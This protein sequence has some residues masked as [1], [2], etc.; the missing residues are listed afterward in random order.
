MK[1]F[2]SIL[3]SFL[4]LFALIPVN[5]IADESISEGDAGGAPSE[6]GVLSAAGTNPESPIAENGD[7]AP[8]GSSEVDEPASDASAPIEE[9]DSS[10]DSVLNGDVDPENTGVSDNASD[11]ALQTEPNEEEPAEDVSSDENPDENETDNS[12]LTE[13]ERMEE[14]AAI[15]EIAVGQTVTGTLDEMESTHTVRLI[16]ERNSA[17]TLTL[18]GGAI[19]TVF[20]EQSEKLLTQIGEKDEA[21]EWKPAETGLDATQGSYLV[22]FSL[23]DSEPSASFSWTANIAE[24]NEIDT[25]EIQQTRGHVT[26]SFDGYTVTADDSSVSVELSASAQSD[27]PAIRGAIGGV[28]YD[29]LLDIVINGSASEEIQAG[30]QSDSLKQQS[31]QKYRVIRILRDNEAERVSEATITEEGSLAFSVRGD[32]LYVLISLKGAEL[33]PTKPGTSAFSVE[34]VSG[35]SLRGEQYVWTP[36]DSSDSNRFV[37]RVHYNL[38]VYSDLDEESVRMIIPKQILKDRDNQYADEIELTIPSQADLESGDSFDADAYFAWREET[39]GAGQPTGNIILYNFRT[40]NPGTNSGSAEL[41]YIPTKSAFAYR[42]YN[43]KDPAGTCSDDFHAVLQLLDGEPIDSEHIAVGIDTEA[44][45]TAISKRGFTLSSGW[46]SS[47]GNASDFGVSASDSSCKYLIW[48]INSSIRATQPYT[49]TINDFPVT[50][51]MEVIGYQWG[52]DSGFSVPAEDGSYSKTNQQGGSRYDFVLTRV[53]ESVYRDAASGQD[54]ARWSVE[55]SAMVTLTPIDGADVVS[56]ATGTGTFSQETPVFYDQQAQFDAWK[57]GDGSARMNSLFGGTSGSQVF[58]ALSFTAGYYSRTDLER[59]G[60]H[61]ETNGDLET[62]DSLDYAVWAWSM[63]YILTKDWNYKDIAS[64]NYGYFRNYVILDQWDSEVKL[65]HTAEDLIEIGKGDY[66]IKK[67][68]FNTLFYDAQ[69]NENTQKFAQGEAVGDRQ[70][71]ADDALGGIGDVLHI[72]GKTGSGEWVELLKKEYRANGA[73]WVNEEYAQLNDNTLTFL[74]SEDHSKD[75]LLFRTVI[76]TRHYVASVGAVPEIELFASEKVLEVVNENGAICLY[77]STSADLYSLWEGETQHVGYNAEGQV[78]EI[79]YSGEDYRS[80]PWNL[81]LGDGDTR[82]Y[83]RFTHIS[84]A[85]RLDYDYARTSPLEETAT[86]QNYISSLRKRVTSTGNDRNQSR[87][88]IGWQVDMEEWLR[89]NGIRTVVPQISGVFYDLLPEGATLDM[90]TLKVQNSD[91]RTN[92]PEDWNRDF[93]SELIPNWRGSGRTMLIVH[94][95][96]WGENYSLSYETVHPWTSIKEYGNNVYNPVAYETGNYSITSGKPD[97]ASGFTYANADERAWMTGLDPNGEGEQRFLYADAKTSISALITLSN[98]TFKRV[99][100]MKDTLYNNMAYV[101]QNEIYV[102]RLSFAPDMQSPSENLLFIDNL[103]NSNA[104]GRQWQGTLYS[105]DPNHPEYAIDVTQLRTAGANPT[106]YLA[107]H[108]VEITNYGNDQSVGDYLSEKGFVA[109]EAF[110]SSHS[111]SEVKSVA[112]YCGDDFR[113]NGT[114][115]DND[116]SLAVYLYMKSPDYIADRGN[117]YPA[118]YNSFALALRVGVSKDDGTTEYIPQL[119]VTPDVVTYCRVSGNVPLKKISAEDSVTA[120]S[121]VQFKLSGTSYYTGNYFE[122]FETTGSDGRLIF[123][124]V[125]RGSYVLEEISCPQEWVLSK[126]LLQIVIDGYG[127]LWAADINV[128][129]T[130]DGQ[131]QTDPESGKPLLLDG[132]IASDDYLYSSEKTGEHVITVQD[133]LRVYSDIRFTKTNKRAGQPIKDVEFRLEGVSHYET[134]V[135]LTATSDA[136]GVVTF[137]DVEWGT[138]SLTETKTPSNYFPLPSSV[139]IMVEV[140]GDHNVKIYEVD[141]VTNQPKE[142]S[143]WLS[144][145]RFGGVSVMNPEKNTDV[146]FFKAE[147]TNDTCRYLPG[148][149]FTLVGSSVDGNSVNREAT[150]DENGHVL[151]ERVEEGLYE[152]TE[153]VAPQNIR[154]TE[155]GEAEFGGEIN[156]KADSNTYYLIVHDNGTFTICLKNSDGSEGAEVERDNSGEYVF[157]NTPIADGELLITK[158]WIDGLTGTAALNRPYPQLSLMTEE[159]FAANYYTVTF[160]AHGGYFAN[161][162]KTYAIRYRADQLPTA[163]QAAAVPAPVRT[164]YLFDGWIYKLTGVEDILTFDLKNYTEKATITVYANWTPARLWEYEY[165]GFAQE[166]TAP[167][168]GDYKMEAWGANGGDPTKYML[169]RR[170]GGTGAYTSGIIHLEEGQKIYVYVG[171]KGANGYLPS[172]YVQIAGGWNGGGYGVDDSNNDE[173]SGGGG[174]ATDFRLVDGAWNSF[175]SLKSRIMVA[176]GGGGSVAVRK[177]APSLLNIT[178]PMDGH[179]ASLPL[180]EVPGFQYTYKVA[181]S[182][183]GEYTY[184]A[185]TA[186][187][188]KWYYPGSFGVGGHADNT[189]YRCNHS[190]GGAGGGWYGGVAGSTQYGANSTSERNSNYGGCATGGISYISGHAGCYAIDQS[191]TQSNIRH[192]STSEYA[193]Y[194]FTD[195]QI[196]AG[197][198]VAA[199]APRPISTK[200]GFARITYLVPDDY[201]DDLSFPEQTLKP[202]TGSSWDEDEIKS[203]NSTDPNEPD[204]EPASGYWEKA[205]DDT[206]VYHFRLIEPNKGYIVFEELGLTYAEY[207][208]HY[209]SDVMTPGYLLIPKG[210]SN[211]TITN[212]LPLGSLIVVKKVSGGDS[213]LKFRFTVTLKNSL[214]QPVN[215]VFGGIGF[216]NGKGTFLLGNNED[217]LISDIPAGYQYEVTE[218]ETTD[219]TAKFTPDTPSGTISSESIAEIRCQNTYTARVIEPVNVTLQKKVTG[220]YETL[221]AFSIRA[222]FRN[223]KPGAVYSYTKNE[224]SY[225]FT[226]DGNGSFG[227][228][229]LSVEN[230]ECVTFE[231]LPV[232]S[233]YKFL[234]EGGDYTASYRIEDSAGKNHIAQSVPTVTAAGT[235]L[236]TA[237]ET[238]DE[239]E[240]IS[241]T[242]ENNVE[243]MA[244]LAISKEVIGLNLGESFEITLRLSNLAAGAQYIAQK[245][246]ENP[247]VWTANGTGEINR[248]IPLKHGETLVIQNLPVGA[249]YRIGEAI[250]SGYVTTMTINGND[251]ALSKTLPSEGFDGG[252]AVSA[253]TLHEGDAPEAVVRNSLQKGALRIT[254]QVSG[255]IGNRYELFTF[256]IAFTYPYGDRIVPLSDISSISAQLNGE[257]A[258]LSFTDGVCE[259]KLK[260]GDELLIEG[261]YAGVQ[262][263]ITEVDGEGYEV[264]VRGNSSGTIQSD[265]NGVTEAAFLNTK[266]AAI[267]TGVMLTIVP[268]VII[269]GI[270]IVGLIVFSRKKKE[271]E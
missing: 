7:D 135:D 144:T 97:D 225:S 27:H 112:V 247:L 105:A 123:T 172:N 1:R 248:T 251:V 136:S 188:G 151:F 230:G 11:S 21:G 220:R 5:A 77:N 31:G 221:G 222:D 63:P 157:Y 3:L 33:D 38:S 223:L 30:V 175:A 2:I 95:L 111:L 110:L 242:F 67:L 246:E 32:G 214:G 132:T 99:R 73:T 245:G 107:D 215:G 52:G 165:K 190:I 201:I 236:S 174:G 58:D 189:T 47:W 262:Y 148:A 18:I 256:R 239:G 119:T 261:I 57:R 249:T 92:N 140:G 126:D 103:E 87:F 29:P 228:L 150:S 143:S 147:K 212:H 53:N 138:Y 198:D 253:Q 204:G 162:N 71:D 93:S 120:I 266:N 166:F 170:Y 187:V 257:P 125:E 141:P 270:A 40:I 117:P 235:A 68:Q 114:D 12:D 15:P 269:V 191:S 142:N 89:V 91:R 265:E 64:E 180:I 194:V 130:L 254:K 133:A 60:T 101:E 69:L 232:G 252:L 177:E 116:K 203:R 263:E 250:Y 24:Q 217:R 41:A 16:V 155:T 22:V 23:P 49:I 59:F 243:R 115:A 121:N 72:F 271:N 218:E 36:G 6:V 20:G 183:K 207:G 209:Q 267:P 241:V 98:G 46:D 61:N 169:G 54:L 208:F 76:K 106:V 197:Y 131:V 129:Q 160:D 8:V 211:A 259:T 62:Y 213:E 35:A 51:G 118:T 44:T 128:F 226:A 219:Y 108:V 233:Q 56:V 65:G 96:D 45:V 240:V 179:G 139:M 39:D 244:S 205:S 152:L 156:Y 75:I 182:A 171:G 258:I 127:R 237:W 153:T 173:C 102:Y 78:N 238:A 83:Y 79:Y 34:L 145:D 37:F 48:I 186:P 28:D 255:N 10:T 26:E 90:K 229:M 234:E 9:D 216:Q 88:V 185:G 164:G 202:A 25:E 149:T 4:M 192:L 176:A 193:G 13:P 181:I 74:D 210:V 206:W 17:L 231:K 264:S 184:S 146:D 86:N 42:D 104:Q 159:A 227:G 260:H 82:A 80:L 124:G 43:S 122:T 199:T 167:V 200:D 100:A 109:I 158:K 84:D 81:D 168:T 163:A 85:N 70:L 94:V 154:I 161:G 224:Q 14:N 178:K 113:M 137:F 55:N 196:V 195:T 50:D 66:R 268:G 134:T 19:A